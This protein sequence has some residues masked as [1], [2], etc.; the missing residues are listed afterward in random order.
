MR[1]T[2]LQKL[3]EER[4]IHPNKRLGQCFLV[5]DNVARWIVDQ[6]GITEDDTVVEVGPGA[7]SLTQHLIGRVRRLVLVEK[8]NK[9]AELLTE[10]Y[11]DLAPA[12]TVIHGDAMDYDVR[13]HFPEGPVKLIGNLP[14]SVGNEIIRTFLNPPSPVELAVVMV[15]REVALRI[16]SDAGGKNY[17]ILSLMMQERW[18]PELLKTVGPQLFFPR[19]AVDSSIIRLTPRAS[20]ELPPHCP[21]V[22]ESLVRRGFSQRRKQLRKNLGVEPELW[23][24]AIEA[25]GASVDTRAQELNLKQWVNLSNLLE[26]HP[27]GKHAQRG[28]EV[29]DV[30]DENDVVTGQSTRAEVHAQGL[31]HR[32]VHVLVFNPKGEVYLQKR[33]ML[34]DT[35]AGKWD[36]SSSGHLDAGEDYA[37][38]AIRELNEELLV[39]PAKPLE[40]LGKVAAGPGTDNEFVEIYRAESRGKG[41]RIHGNEIDC[42]GFFPL[43][44]VD[45]WIATRPEDFATGFKTTFAAVRGNL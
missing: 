4:D 6:A 40:R 34:K 38:A 27:A 43:P 26:P 30:V 3:F 36:S 18:K 31:L 35:H 45:E 28:D 21:Q 24:P 10:R 15:Q 9:L 13:Q 19:P 33:S 32:A 11:A 14:Y 42:G 41:F 5:D 7:G 29:F 1:L 8:D 25:I 44:L 2:D 39:A 37:A 17:G 12:V 22:F 23:N 20:G 16:C